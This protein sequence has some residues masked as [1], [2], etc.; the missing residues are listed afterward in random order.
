M[1][2]ESDQ[3]FTEQVARY[4]KYSTDAPFRYGQLV[5]IQMLGHAM[6]RETVHLI[7]PAEV[8]L[9]LF[10]CIVGE[11]TISRKSTSQSLGKKVYPMERSIPEEMS[12]EQFLVELSET[13]EAI[14]WIGEFTGLLKG[15]S[16]KGYMARFVELYNDLHSCE[17]YHRKLRDKKNVR[18]DFRIDEPYLSLNSTVT[19][20]MLKRFLTEELA[21]GGFL[22]RWLLVEDTPDPQP[23]R[24]LPP[25]TGQ[26]RIFVRN[27]INAVIG[28]QKDVTFE[29]DNDSLALFNEIE[30]EAYSFINALPF[31]GRYLNYVI[32]IADILM[33]SDA[34]GYQME[35]ANLW[36]VSS[37]SELQWLAQ[38][39]VNI[40]TIDDKMRVVVP[41][42]YVQKAWEIIKPC[43]TYADSTLKHIRLDVPMQ[44]LQEVIERH[45]T[46]GHSQAMRLT[47]LDRR[48]M[49]L[50][51]SSLADMNV[52]KIEKVPVQR[53]TSVGT[54]RIYHYVELDTASSRQ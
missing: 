14:Q 25:N 32:A 43:L 17:P 6:G 42:V 49:A 24:N 37:M 52:I 31:A 26:M 5:G 30:D 39:S 45:G 16:G 36:S 10:L 47:G 44:K 22:A 48:K 29:F 50:A 51:I 38:H 12:P 11:S 40:S 23:R 21:E 41:P 2:F 9:N 28:Y 27:L 34:V 3:T 18:S 53:K 35:E 15:V 46:I 8:H 33:M 13:P 7:Q 4:Y 19:P 20:K 54:K 1:S